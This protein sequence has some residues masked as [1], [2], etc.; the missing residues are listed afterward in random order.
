MHQVR[1]VDHDP[2]GTSSGTRTVL[3]ECEIVRLYRWPFPTTHAC[4]FQFVSTNP[5][6]TLSRT[7]ETLGCPLDRGGGQNDGGTGIFQYPLQPISCAA[8]SGNRDRYSY[9]S[10][11]KTSKKAT[12][13]IQPWPVQ[14]QRPI[15]LLGNR[16]QFRGDDAGL[17]IQLLISQV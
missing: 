7:N 8:T 14:Q 12:D 10:R 5:G 2:L 6:Q 1:M 11:V 15:S 3:K 17:N 13:E 4:A 16:A 9:D